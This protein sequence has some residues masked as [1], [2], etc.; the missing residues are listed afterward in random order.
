MKRSSSL[1]LLADNRIERAG[2][3][4]PVKE[5]AFCK[6]RRFRFDR[7]WLPFS[8]GPKQATPVALEL[9]GGVYQKGWHQSIERY[10]SDIEK[11]NLAAL[12]GWLVIRASVTHVESGQ[13]IE[14][15]SRALLE[16]SA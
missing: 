3:P 1:E 4:L 2:L 7:A 12:A 15:L 6:P 10:Q 13:M 9:E 16:T 8:A 14:W 5:Y 11:Y